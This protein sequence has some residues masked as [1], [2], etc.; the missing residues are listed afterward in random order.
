LEQEKKRHF[1]LENFACTTTKL[2]LRW[3]LCWINRGGFLENRHGY[4]EPSKPPLGFKTATVNGLTVAVNI[5]KPSQLIN[6]NR[7]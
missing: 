2:E 7:F 5:K 1:P 6:I 4:F 3:H